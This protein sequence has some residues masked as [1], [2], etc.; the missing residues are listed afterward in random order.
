[1]ASR[2]LVEFLREVDAFS[3]FKDPEIEKLAD[4]GGRPLEDV[5][6][7]IAEGSENYNNLQSRLREK[8][9]FEILL[10]KN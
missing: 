1:M 5:K 6:K 8:K 4:E 9:I 2:E 10:E 3:A 7:A